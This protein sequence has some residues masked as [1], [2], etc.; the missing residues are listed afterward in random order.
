MLRSG[1]NVKRSL[2]VRSKQ[3]DFMSVA[4]KAKKDNVLGIQK[5]AY[6]ALMQAKAANGGELTYGN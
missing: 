4:K 6:A 2:P 3:L 5:Q 1:S